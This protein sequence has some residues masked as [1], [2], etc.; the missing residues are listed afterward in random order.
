MTVHSQLCAPLSK[1]VFIVCVQHVLGE[2]EVFTQLGNILYV[3]RA[4]VNDSS[5]SES[6]RS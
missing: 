5:V 1:F 4:S 2:V 6:L 3:R